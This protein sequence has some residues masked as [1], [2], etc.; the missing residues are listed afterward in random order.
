M[1][2]PPDNPHEDLAEACV[3]SMVD[4]AGVDLGGLSA[5]LPQ[6]PDDQDSLLLLRQHRGTLDALALRHAYHDAS[7]HC[8]LLPEDAV[9]RALFDVFEQERFESIGCNAFAGVQINLDARHQ[10]V[11]SDRL[12]PAAGSATSAHS[13]P[14]ERFRQAVHALCQQRLRRRVAASS[15]HSDA[16]ARTVNSTEYASLWQVFAEPL[17][18]ELGALVHDQQGFGL[19]VQALL[20]KWRRQSAASELAG[21]MHAGS[22]E[23]TQLQ[24]PSASDSDNDTQ[25]AD[26]TVQEAQNS[27]PAEKDAESRDHDETRGETDSESVHIEA[28]VDQL[29]DEAPMSGTDPVIHVSGEAAPYKAY[30][31]EFDEICHASAYA[32]QQALMRWRSE[33]DGHIDVH[34]RLVRRLASRLQ[35]VLLARQ[36]RHWQF[37]MEEGQLDSSR[38][39]RIVTQPLVPLSFK[40]ESE[41]NMRDTTITLLIDN[42]RSMLGRP[43]M[44]AAAATDILART[45]ERC[46]VSVEIL[47]FSTAQLHGGRST[48]QWERD[49]CPENPG[50]LNDLRHIIYKS[51]DTPYRKARRHLGLMLDKDILKQNIDGE[52]LLWAY[53]RLGKRPEK[54]R[55]LMII[56]DGAPVDASTLSA[57]N[58]D[59][60][61]RHLQQVASD[62]ERAGD[63]EL[64][65]IGIGH[66]VARFYSHAL[67]VFDARQLGPVMLNELESLLRKAA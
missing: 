22:T 53:S 67:S 37:D 60:L 8:Q 11:G 48:Q 63:V 47:G 16:C 58:G 59:Y 23:H 31:T 25:D 19:K 50:R 6:F 14:V 64:L 4:D 3:R 56:S 57:N 2:L 10:R 55:I 36:R 51:A 52:A 30:T 40:N 24:D 26:E 20:K 32:D 33:L 42:S 21:E 41:T 35:R 62:I 29:L 5:A 66:D 54:R 15:L 39:S 28:L 49:G 43:I 9:E 1:P 44:I 7:L 17:S 46:G 61:A 18:R 13:T 65:A 34:A 45:L 12:A 38:L 27:S